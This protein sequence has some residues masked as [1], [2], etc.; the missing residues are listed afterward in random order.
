MLK[1]HVVVAGIAGV[2]W[3]LEQVGVALLLDAIA[4]VT[5]SVIVMILIASVGLVV[6]VAA[7]LI[8]A[9]RHDGL[10]CAAGDVE[11]RVS[12]VMRC[13]NVGPASEDGRDAMKLTQSV[14]P[15]ALAAEHRGKPH[16][17]SGKSRIRMLLSR[18]V[19]CL[20]SRRRLS[21]Q[22]SSADSVARSVSTLVSEGEGECECGWSEL[23]PLIL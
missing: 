1:Q 15:F 5:V 4:I 9:D 3:G 23:V 10:H 13:Q 16:R 18:V 12:S 20:Q 7:T 2:E 17:I 22:R 14:K 21:G 11:E 6:P 8:P 19:A